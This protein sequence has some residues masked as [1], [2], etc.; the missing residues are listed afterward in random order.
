[1]ETVEDFA[2]CLSELPKGYCFDSRVIIIVKARL[3][4]LEALDKTNN[5]ALDMHIALLEKCL[6]YNVRNYK[7]H[8]KDHLVLLK[9]AISSVS[10]L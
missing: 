7:L 5:Q 10:N 6:T 2:K 3:A 8:Y 4:E 9:G 1:M